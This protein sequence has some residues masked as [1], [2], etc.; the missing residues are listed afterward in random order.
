MQPRRDWSTLCGYGGGS[1]WCEDLDAC[2]VNY[3][4]AHLM[5]H[6]DILGLSFDGD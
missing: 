3:S 6:S 2:M 5:H 1:H 4:Y